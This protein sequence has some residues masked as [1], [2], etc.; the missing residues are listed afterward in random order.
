VSV[1]TEVADAKNARAHQARVPPEG[2]DDA[3][4]QAGESARGGQAFARGRHARRPAPG[5]AN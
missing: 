1:R 3:A 4:G 5:S 2:C